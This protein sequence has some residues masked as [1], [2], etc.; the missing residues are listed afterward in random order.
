[1]VSEFYLEQLKN[2]DNTALGESVHSTIEWAPVAAIHNKV[3]C[4][5]EHK[6]I[7]HDGG[8]IE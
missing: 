5:Q 4:D 3:W 1:M 8:F 7:L 2:L 6:G